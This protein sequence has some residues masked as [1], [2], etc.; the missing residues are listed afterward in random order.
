LFCLFFVFHGENTEQIRAPF[1]GN[2]MQHNGYKES[3]S[4][5]SSGTLKPI[6]SAT[7]LILHSFFGSA[8][9]CASPPR[10]SIFS[11]YSSWVHHPVSHDDRHLLAHAMASDFSVTWKCLSKRIT[12]FSLWI[13]LHATPTLL[14]YL[15]VAKVIP[16]NN[17]F[18]N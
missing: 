14:T 13:K 18:L 2:I 8:A 11:D 15:Y 12:G 1:W 10:P 6:P 3:M 5:S 7:S 9:P 17:R 16:F 4:S